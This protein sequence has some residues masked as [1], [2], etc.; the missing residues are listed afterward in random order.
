MRELRAD[1]ELQL[2]KHFTAGWE[3]TDR[4]R[5]RFFVC[6]CFIVF[7]CFVCESKTVHSSS[8]QSIYETYGHYKS[9]LFGEVLCAFK[10]NASGLVEQP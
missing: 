8:Q 2:H 5:V 10:Y 3:V 9:S 1:T 4:V 6:F 7:F